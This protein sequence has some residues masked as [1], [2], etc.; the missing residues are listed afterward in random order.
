[1][2]ATLLKKLSVATV[3]GEFD[4]NH[5][6]VVNSSPIIRVFGIASGIRTGQSNFGDWLAFTGDFG[7]I[8]LETGEAYRG[9][10][11]FIPQPAQGMLEAA[12]QKA[13]TVEFSFEIGLKPSKKGTLGF[14]YT[15][16]PIKEAADSDA[17]TAL[18]DMSRADLPALGHDGGE[19]PKA[20]G[21]KK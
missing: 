21:K 4:K 5:D 10:Q 15:V 13:E 11:V 20:K 19:T 2:N 6:A 16:R 1:M 18:A 3:F 8:N 7:A 12:L 9:P 14:E 17:F